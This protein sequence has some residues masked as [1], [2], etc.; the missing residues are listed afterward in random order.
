MNWSVAVY[1]GEADTMA[2]VYREWEA[3]GDKARVATYETCFKSGR[4]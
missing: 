1:Q 2:V 4:L 3:G